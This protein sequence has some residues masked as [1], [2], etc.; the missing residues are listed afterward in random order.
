M[1]VCQSVT[2]RLFWEGAGRGARMWECVFFLRSEIVHGAPPPGWAATKITR[3]TIDHCSEVSREIN[4]NLRPLLQLP[5]TAHFDI[6]Y[7]ST[8]GGG[9]IY[10]DFGDNNYPTRHR[11]YHIPREDRTKVKKFIFFL[12]SVFIRSVSLYDI[13]QTRWKQ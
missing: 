5:S 13:I 12:Y 4:K 9:V 10:H 3:P 11:Y 1:A 2:Q 7:T 6:L 8:C